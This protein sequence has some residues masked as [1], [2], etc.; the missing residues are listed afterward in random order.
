MSEIR[1]DPYLRGRIY[2]P[3]G[4]KNKQK[5]GFPYSVLCTLKITRFQVFHENLRMDPL[6]FS[7]LGKKFQKNQ[8]ELKIFIDAEILFRQRYYHDVITAAET[9]QVDV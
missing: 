2:G 4:R 8:F 6:L 7:V 9:S 1:F 5:F 3:I